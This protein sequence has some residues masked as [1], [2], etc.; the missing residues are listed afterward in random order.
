M[1]AE[2][3]LVGLCIGHQYPIDGSLEDGPEFTFGLLYGLHRLLALGDVIY[4]GNE[5]DGAIFRIPYQRNAQAYP[6]DMT[7]LVNISLLRL[8]V[9]Y[10]PPAIA[11]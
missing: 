7:I 5:M 10:H 4:L 6:Y 3:E 8:E 1:V 2:Y 11:P 9:I